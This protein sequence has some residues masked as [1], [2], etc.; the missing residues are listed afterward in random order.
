MW[1]GENEKG[2]KSWLERFTNLTGRERWDRKFTALRKS[3]LK[4]ASTL[5]KKLSIKLGGS[6]LKCEDFKSEKN[7][8]WGFYTASICLLQNVFSQKVESRL[9]HFFFF[10]FETQM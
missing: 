9:R 2:A 1:T 10:F 7:F 4:V 6:F 8:E 5:I 3:I